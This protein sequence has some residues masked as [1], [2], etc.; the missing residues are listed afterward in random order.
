MKL[1]LC[2]STLTVTLEALL[3][4]VLKCA[5]TI[6]GVPCVMMT[7]DSRMAWWYAGSLDG[8]ELVSVIGF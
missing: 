4:G 1:E 2:D 6:P 8:E 7:G 3:Q 5:I